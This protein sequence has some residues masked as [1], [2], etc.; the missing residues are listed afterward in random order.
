MRAHIFLNLKK[1]KKKKYFIIPFWKTGSPYLGKTQPQREQRYT[2]SCQ[3]VQ[4]FPVSKQ[5]YSCQCLPFW[6]WALMLPTRGLYEHWKGFCAESCLWENNPLPHQEI[7]RTRDSI[8]PN[9]QFDALQLSYLARWVMCFLF[10]LFLHSISDYSHTI[11]CAGDMH[12]C[13]S[14][15]QYLCIYS[16]I[17]W[18]PTAVWIMSH[19]FINSPGSWIHMNWLASWSVQN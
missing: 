7:S 5:C 3:C 6:T 12:A 18:L 1:K 8:T 4:Y 17:N 2:H 14:A 10:V 11:Y 9:F 16:W 19:T 15:C 13:A